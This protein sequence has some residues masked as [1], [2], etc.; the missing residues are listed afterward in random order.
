[1]PIDEPDADVA[2]LTP[3]PQQHLASG[4]EVCAA[5]GRVTFGTDAGMALATFSHLVGKDS[6]AD[7]LFYASENP[8]SGI[9]KATYRGRFVEY[10]GAL[11]NGKAPPSCAQFR[12]PTTANDGPWQSFYVVRNL[13][14]LESPVELNKLSKR[15]AKGKLRSNFI[16]LGPVV[17][18]TPF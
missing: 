6:N 13:R 1:M 7:V 9:P 15:D 14:R 2:L 16:P 3:V 17:I 12:P 4:V 11:A 18:D 5:L 8:I 10:V